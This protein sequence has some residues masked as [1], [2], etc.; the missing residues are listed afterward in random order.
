MEKIILLILII[1]NIPIYK[2]LFK[3]F[4]NNMSGFYECFISSDNPAWLSIRNGDYLNEWFS[5]MKLFAFGGCCVVIVG[6][7]YFITTNV[8]D[9]F[10]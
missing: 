6:I 2:Y 9:K 7:E 4:F 1:V 8:V 10:F 5:Q 3:K